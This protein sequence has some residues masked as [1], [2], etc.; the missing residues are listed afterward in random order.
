MLCQG[1]NNK[2]VAV[3]RAVVA[4]DVV[5]SWGDLGGPTVLMMLAHLALTQPH[6]SSLPLKALQVG[7]ATRFVNHEDFTCG[8]HHKIVQTSQSK[9]LTSYAVPRRV[10]AFC[11]MLRVG[12]Q[13]P[14]AGH[15]QAAALSVLRCCA[16]GCGSASMGV[17]SHAATPQN[18]GPVESRKRFLASRLLIPSP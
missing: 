2:C 14:L 10:L 6:C 13:V 16:S 5:R 7:R 12:L 18:D 17:K 3:C 11:N 8:G 1:P 4:V 9:C 15:E